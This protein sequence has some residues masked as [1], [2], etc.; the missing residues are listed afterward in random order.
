MIYLTQ[1]KLMRAEANAQLGSDLT[2]AVE[3]VNAIISRAYV[4]M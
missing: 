3:D 1:L 4:Q 2:T